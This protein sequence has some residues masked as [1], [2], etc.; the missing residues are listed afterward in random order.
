MSV[1]LKSLL[2]N[3]I[4]I[5]KRIIK[6]NVRVKAFTRSVKHGGRPVL[7]RFHCANHESNIRTLGS[8]HHP[9]VHNGTLTIST[10]SYLS[11][12]LI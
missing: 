2:K 11:S 8:S 12:Y 4:T 6:R 1:T 3:D 10:T 7:R 9:G 5:V